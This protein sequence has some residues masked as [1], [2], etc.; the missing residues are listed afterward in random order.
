MIGSMT[1][2]WL[3]RCI[4]PSRTRLMSTVM[5]AP[6]S[7][8]SKSTLRLFEYLRKKAR[9]G[10]VRVWLAVSLPTSVASAWLV[11]RLKL[12]KPSG[13]CVYMLS[14]KQFAPAI[15]IFLDLGVLGRFSLKYVY[16]SFDFCIIYLNFQ[17]CYNFT[18]FD[19]IS[20]KKGTCSYPFS[21]KAPRN[22]DT[23]YNWSQVFFCSI[24]TS[25]I[26]LSF[27]FPVLVSPSLC[28]LIFSLCAHLCLPVKV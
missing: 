10:R 3:E 11:F 21:G 18:Y 22:Q 14:F 2:R 6:I 7:N 27:L 8:F 20:L 19:L 9:A 4:V 16:W 28:F 5:I 24:P 17:Y 26:V 25:S 1:Q 15:G 23:T 12:R 13:V